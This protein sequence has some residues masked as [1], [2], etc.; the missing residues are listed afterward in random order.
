MVVDTDV[1]V[2]F[3]TG[4]DSRKAV[5]FKNCLQRGVNL[6]LKDVTFAEIY[7]TLSS[8]YRFPRDQI[9]KVLE[10]LLNTRSLISNQPILQKT[11]VLLLTQKLSF[12]DAYLAA[13]SLL[14]GDGKIMSYDRGFDKVAGLQRIEPL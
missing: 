10:G 8:F 3:L 12:I 7:W 5:R 14:E 6:I 2:R 11:L 1:I 4:D 9:I 13:F